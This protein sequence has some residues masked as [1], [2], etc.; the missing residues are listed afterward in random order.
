MFKNL[1]AL[2]IKEHETKKAHVLARIEADE[3]YLKEYS[4][5]RKWEQYQNGEIDRAQATAYA[6]KRAAKEYEKRTQKDLEKLERA[7]IE[8]DVKSVSISVEWKRS[9]TWGHNPHAHVVINDWWSYNGTASGCGYDKET[10]AI[11]SAL[12]QSDSIKKMLYTCK[13]RAIENGYNPEDNK[14]YPGIE[15]NRECI[16]YGAGYGTLPYFEGGVGMS[17]FEGVFNACGLRLVTRH[18][19]KHSDYY[20]FERKEA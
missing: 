6:Q 5:A 18:S 10:A 12:N 20:Y 17:S 7:A 9:S 1:K 16:N 11:G 3:A 15:S 19:T 14:N 2:V 4:T 13:E 8:P